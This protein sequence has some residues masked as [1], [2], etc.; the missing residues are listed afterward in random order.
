MP[1]PHADELHVP[2]EKLDRY[3]LDPDHPFGGGKADW[4]AG[5]GYH[6]CNAECLADDLIELARRSEA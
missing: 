2:M 6:R 5:H 1:I 4:F 3:L